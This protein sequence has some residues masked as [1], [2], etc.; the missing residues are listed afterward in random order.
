MLNYKNYGKQVY[1]WLMTKHNTDATFT[2]SLRQNGTKGAEL[3][4][5]IGTENSNYITN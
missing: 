4:Y 2:F 1:D 5:F 3:D